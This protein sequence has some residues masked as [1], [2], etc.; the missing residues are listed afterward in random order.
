MT[1]NVALIGCGLNGR[2]HSTAIRAIARRGMLDI[3]YAAVCDV[4]PARAKSFA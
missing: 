1:L 3:N 4:D 2:F